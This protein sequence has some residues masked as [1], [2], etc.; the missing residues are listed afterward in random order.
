MKYQIDYS[1]SG[2]AEE[3]N[4]QPRLED[5]SGRHL[6]RYQKRRRFV[7]PDIAKTASTFV[8]AG[9][10]FFGAEAMA[11]GAF[12]P[13]TLM[14]TY[15]AR[16]SSAV[17]AAELTQQA[18][19]EV[20]LAEAKLSVDQQLEQYRALNQG[21]LAN[22]QAT[23]DRGRIMAEATARIQ[24]QYVAARMSQT[25]STQATDVAIVNW[26]RFFGR[27]AET[28]EPGAG[29]AALGYADNLSAQLSNE[30]TAAATQG[31]TID[32]EGW[33]TGLKPVGE[34]QQEFA[35]LKPI[36]LPP[37]PALGEASSTT[38]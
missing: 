19:Y 27:V 29:A 4:P 5:E 11:P 24:S 36:V 25:Q 17:K 31:V 12:K 32:V 10:V 20:W 26:T 8:L 6:V 16:V 28:L 30:L 34:L 38:R 15:D 3:S 1:A 18:R 13:S 7:L 14:G 21:V 23:Y 37:P 33:D 22:Y 9:A 35:A 2:S